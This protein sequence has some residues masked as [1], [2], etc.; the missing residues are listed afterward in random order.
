MRTLLKRIILWALADG[1]PTV[2]PSAA[3]ELDKIAADL[4]N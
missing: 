3:A 4:K 2:T 1:A